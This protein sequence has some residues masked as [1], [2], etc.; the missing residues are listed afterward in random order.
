MQRKNKCVLALSSLLAWVGVLA[1]AAPPVH[2]ASTHEKK[3]D[4]VGRFRLFLASEGVAKEYHEWK[5]LEAG[6]DYKAF[7]VVQWNDLKMLKPPA[8]GGD[9]KYTDFTINSLNWK[10]VTKHKDG[11]ITWTPNCSRLK[12]GHVRISMK[13]NFCDRHALVEYFKVDCSKGETGKQLAAWSAYEQI[14][15]LR[16]KAYGWKYISFK[17]DKDGGF[18]S[19]ATALKRMPVYAHGGL[20]QV[21]K[22]GKYGYADAKTGALKIPFKY[23]DGQA[24][25]FHGRAMVKDATGW[26]WIDTNGKQVIS[27]KPY[28][29]VSIFSGG[30]AAVSKDNKRFGFIDTDGKPITKFKY[31]G[32]KG[33]SWKGFAFVTDGKGAGFIDKRGKEVIPLVYTNA[34][35]IPYA[36]RAVVEKNG[37][38]GIVDMRHRFIVPLKYDDAR[39]YAGGSGDPTHRMFARLKK[40][41]KWAYVK[42]D[43]SFLTEFQFREAGAFNARGSEAKVVKVEWNGNKPRRVSGVVDNFGRVSWKDGTTSASTASSGSRTSSGKGQ[44]GPTTLTITNNLPSKRNTKYGWVRLVFDGG[45]IA[46]KTL[47]RSQSMTIDCKRVRAVYAARGDSTNRGKKLFSVKGRCGKTVRLSDVW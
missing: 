21:K 36:D 45:T 25:F 19:H 22:G 44:A 32:Y 3:C 2:A 6:K 43:G 1:T 8:M 16:A 38:W 7:G 33:A 12:K 10:V 18:Y 39:P 17:P 34:Y 13:S 14:G 28:A 37:R 20:V 41:D 23:T 40:G 4:K 47:S 30:I 35:P 11:S 26:N 15:Y 29:N 5:V 27:G 24:S 46:N 9:L 42:H 31:T